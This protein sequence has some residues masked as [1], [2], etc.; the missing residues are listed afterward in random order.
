M[1]AT[2]ISIF[3]SHIKICVVEGVAYHYYVGCLYLLLE[4]DSQV[5][6]GVSYFV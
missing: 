3:M 6:I 4:L 5:P 2:K 1:D